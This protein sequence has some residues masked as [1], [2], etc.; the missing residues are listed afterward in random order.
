M[1][2]EAQ[3]GD[4]TLALTGE[5]LITRALSPFREDGFVR[6][7]ELLRSADVAFTDA[8]MLFHDY[9]GCLGVARAGTWMRA[10]PSLIGDL[11]WAGIDL[12]ATAMNH[13]YDFGETGVTVN[14][15]NL[16]KHGMV[17]AGTGENL[18]LARAPGYL[19]TPKERVALLAACDTLRVPGGKGVDQRPDMKGKLGVNLI[20]VENLYTVDR[21]AWLELQRIGEGLGFRPAAPGRRTDQVPR[22][23]GTDAEGWY[24]FGSG[25]ARMKMRGGDRFGRTTIVDDRDLAENVKWIREARRMA[26]WVLYPTFRRSE[27]LIRRFYRGLT[28]LFS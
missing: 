19:D 25:A 24:Q 20:G 10:D 22:Q 23:P 28:A 17:Y 15:A 5:S 14:I 9:E 11:R 7:V 3:G 8:E 16:K 2:Y 4:L 26:D 6:L 13:A 18:A 12:C 27:R 1:R 21:R